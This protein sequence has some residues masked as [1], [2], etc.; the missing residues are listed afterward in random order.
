M[1]TRPRAMVVLSAS[2]EP[3]SS[4]TPSFT[5][6]VTPTS[7]RGGGTGPDHV[8]LLTPANEFANTWNGPQP[9]FTV[10][11]NAEGSKSRPPKQ[12]AG[13]PPSACSYSSSSSWYAPLDPLGATRCLCSR[14]DRHSLAA[15]RFIQWKSSP[16]SSSLEEFEVLSGRAVAW[17]WSPADE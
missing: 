11:L 7:L 4:A 1:T 12:L 16:F 6:S 9:L 2:T 3:V 15:L 10:K 17:E 13:P 14:R 5:R 8:G